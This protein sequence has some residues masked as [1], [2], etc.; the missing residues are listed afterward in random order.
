MPHLVWEQVHSPQLIFILCL[1][2]HL[3]A[4]G[5]AHRP[6]LPLVLQALQLG[7]HGKM[8]VG[9][10]GQRRRRQSRQGHRLAS[11]SL[12]AARSCSMSGR[13]HPQQTRVRLHMV[14]GR[15]ITVCRE[16]KAGRRGLQACFDKVRRAG[17]PRHLGKS[18]QADRH[19]PSAALCRDRQTNRSQLLIT[20]CLLPPGKRSLQAA[21]TSSSRQLTAS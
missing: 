14:M 16:G 8:H 1:D 5:A 4:A 18:C 11:L 12:S 10:G 3:S 13:R 17:L 2:W 19:L 6:E 9:G 21:Q 15:H 20:F 7:A